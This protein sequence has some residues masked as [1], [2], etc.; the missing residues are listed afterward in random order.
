M[1]HYDGATHNMAQALVN[2]DFETGSLDPWTC[3]SGGAVVS[4]PVHGG[5]H[6]L[7]AAATASQTGACAQTLTLS[8]DTTY[9][10]SGWVQ[11]SYGYLGV[12]GDASASVWGS[13]GGYAK[14]SVTF[15]TGSTGTVTVYL[16]GWYEQGTVYGDDISVTS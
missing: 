3:E 15:T 16:H 14:Q 13:S 5:A 9:T 12:R 11:G 2:G 6:A 10:L 8:P 7:A 1:P 4:T